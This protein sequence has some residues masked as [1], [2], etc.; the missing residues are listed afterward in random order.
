MKKQDLVL[1]SSTLNLPN[2][3]RMSCKDI[4][5]FFG[6]KTVSSFHSRI[7]KLD[8]PKAELYAIRDTGKSACRTSKLN[9]WTLGT[10]RA[11]EIEQNKAGDL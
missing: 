5:V 3:T 4:Y 1:P 8:F 6:Y 7:Y 11:Y 9:Y 2:K 10:L